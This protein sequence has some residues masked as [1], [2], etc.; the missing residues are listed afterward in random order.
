M[1]PEAT[2]P[3]PGD[4]SSSSVPTHQL[5]KALA[6]PAFCKLWIAL[7]LSSLGDWLGLLAATAFAASL[8]SGYRGGLFATG[9]VLASR[10]APAVLFGPF[11]G[12]FA[13]R[14]DRRKQMVLCDLIRA[15]LVTS[16]IVVHTLP[17]LLAASFAIEIFSLFWIPAKEAS[18]PNL[19]PRE[20]LE[21]ANQISLVTTYGMALVAAVLF[22]LLSVLTRAL[23]SPESYFAN[24]PIMLAFGF[25]AVT[26]LISAGTIFSLREISEQGAKR[27]GPAAPQQS[28]ARAIV[29]G[30]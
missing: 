29:E 25:D 11:A 30:W 16:I 20:Q 17:Y 6:I 26:F 14:F 22:S 7:G 21:A 15:S 1:P 4:V 19:V 18:V 3:N 24:E 10:L 12:A 5:S 23:T 28:M 9:A 13:D 27:D 8:V 2:V